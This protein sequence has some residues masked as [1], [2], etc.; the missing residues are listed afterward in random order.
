MSS[1]QFFPRTMLKDQP[2][3]ETTTT[4]HF[5]DVTA[6]HFRLLL[7]FIYK[8]QVALPTIDHVKGLKDLLELLQYENVESLVERPEAATPEPEPERASTSRAVQ[9]KDKDVVEKE[10]EKE[11]S[12]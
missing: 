11:R 8:G 3:V 12:K 5:P 2:P 7:E 9:K 10:K 4:I 1:R 6:D